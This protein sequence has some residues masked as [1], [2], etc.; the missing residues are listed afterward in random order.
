VF[1]QE[2]PFEQLPVNIDEYAYGFWFRYLTH[3]PTRMWNGKNAGWYFVARLTSNQAYADG[4]VG[5][6]LFVCYQGGG[7]YQTGTDGVGNQNIGFPEDIEGLWTYHYF[8]YS[9]PNKRAVA[10]WKFGDAAVQ[11]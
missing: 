5:D 7:I 4:G 2:I 9:R 8:S 11:R 6:K 1:S 10:F 3:Y